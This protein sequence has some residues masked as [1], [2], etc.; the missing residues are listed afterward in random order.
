[1]NMDKKHTAKTVHS[2]GVH[3]TVTK[4]W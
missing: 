1:M 4:V 3:T 2:I